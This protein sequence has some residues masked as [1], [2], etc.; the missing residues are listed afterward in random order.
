L[1]LNV[2]EADEV[3]EVP[4][5]VTV[6]VAGTAAEVALNVATLVVAVVAGLNEAVTPAGRPEALNVTL[7]VKPFLGVT[8]I[9]FVPL[10]PCTTLSVGVEAVIEKLAGGAT[11]KAIATVSLRVPDLPVTVTVDEPAAALAL[12]TKVNVLEVA[13][14]AGPNVAVTP[15]GNP[16]TAKLTALLNPLVGETATDAVAFAP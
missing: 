14:L 2:T 16:E 11:V 1:R 8:V 15:V 12:A 4:I 7:P 6:V 9:V 5:T 10:A 13:V 3:P